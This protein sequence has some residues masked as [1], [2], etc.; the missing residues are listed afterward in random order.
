[1][2][3]RTGGRLVV[4]GG[5]IGGMASAAL[6]ARAGLQVTVVERNDQVGGRARIWQKDG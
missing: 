6:L 3:N 1:M 2:N 4:I 5:G